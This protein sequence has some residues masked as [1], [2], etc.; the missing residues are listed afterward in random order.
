MANHDLPIIQPWTMV[1]LWF[2]H[3][4]PWYFGR[5]SVTS[6]TVA[7]IADLWW[8][9][10]KYSL[11]PKGKIEFLRGKNPITPSPF[12]S[13]F[14][15]PV[16]HFGLLGRS[17]QSSS[18]ASGQVVAFHSLNNAS[19]RPLYWHVDKFYNQYSPAKTKLG[20]L[21]FQYEC[22]LLGFDRSCEINVGSNGPLVRND[23]LRVQWSRVQWRHV[24]PSINIMT[25]T[26][27]GVNI[28]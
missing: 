1:E 11:Y 22:A 9:F 16:M 7:I 2:N 28:S 5:V 8:N 18:E 6:P 10:A 24:T 27:V 19:R 26:F 17:E 13:I 23:I 3:G 14:F 15:V 20:W 21:H 25:S 4:S 12:T